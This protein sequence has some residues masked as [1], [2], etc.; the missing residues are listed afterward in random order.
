MNL[1]FFFGKSGRR[2]F[3]AGA[4]CIF[5][6][7]V[8]LLSSFGVSAKNVTYDDIPYKNY[9]YWTEGGNKR[10][11]ETK[12]VYEPLTAVSLSE[13]GDSGKM[14]LEY[15]CR[16][17]K[18]NINVL[19]S[20][21]GAIYVFDSEYNYVCTVNSVDANGEKL[22]FT[23]AKGIC[24]DDNDT[25]YISDTQNQRVI[26]RLADNSVKIL[27]KPES[28]IIPDGF[29]FAPLLAVR[30]NNGFLYILCEGSYY[31]L[32]V[33]SS[34]DEFIGF[35][36]ATQV[37]K[38]VLGAITDLITSAFETKEKHE[39]S[40]KKLP[41]QI[42]DITVSTGGFITAVTSE[43]KGQI[44]MFS[45]SGSNILRAKNQ[46]SYT[47][48]DD[49]NFADNPN[50]F[51]LA[52]AKYGLLSYEKFAGVTSDNNGYIY[53]LDAT[54]GRIFMYDEYCNLISIFGGGISQGSQLGTFYTPVSI[55]SVGDDL[56]VVDFI[57]KNLTV[58]RLTDFGRKLKSAQQLT[59]EGQYSEAE[60]LWREILAKDKNCQLAYIGL[61]KAELEIGNYS[62]A[63][64]YAKIG[65]DQ[66]TYSQAYKFVRNQFISENFKWLALIAVLVI[67]LLFA[68]KRL[69]RK[70]GVTVK[71]NDKIKACFAT[72][73]KPIDTFNQEIRVKN[74][75]S[76]VLAVSLLI[77]FYVSSVCTKLL[78]G[79]SFNLINLTDFNAFY[80]FLGTVGTVLLYTTVNWAVCTLFEG[81][82]SIKNI[83]IAS[84]YSLW[85]LIINYVLFIVLSH[86]LIPTDS[87]S[88]AIMG[89]AFEI[90]FVVWLLLSITTIHDFSFF[91]ALG[92][93][94]LILLG[95]AVAIFVIFVMLTLGQNLIA[96]LL[97][98]AQEIR[99]R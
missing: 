54:V 3:S 45:P 93:T 71:V 67:V 4:F 18:G 63:M 79:F 57:N 40:V 60:P 2:I 75:G 22:S 17:S 26:C 8:M 88:L 70:K 90:M 53:A 87:S 30:D 62:A 72:I 49:Y 7:P 76:V 50:S 39:A 13:F 20:G 37:Q 19:D 47:G 5:L 74:N 81:K 36:G 83:F 65:L 12:A 51:V 48:G 78:G 68:V 29:S 24:Y 98:V 73:Y 15:V 94:L 99:M 56:A 96:F 85:P 58:F 52:T 82:G 11:V 9:T 32:M 92:M 35:F 95:M 16:D 34:E 43:S 23:G 97:S 1:K 38:S 33:L 41:Y 42:E 46:F 69:L 91:K 84:C 28:D 6:I 10:A 64:K 61:A 77:I 89:T 14:Q 21:N 66:K 31:G 86:V 27:T 55:A 59:N 44:R 25:L 80:T